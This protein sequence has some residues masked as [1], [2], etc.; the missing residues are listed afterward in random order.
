[1]KDKIVFSTTFSLLSGDGGTYRS[2]VFRR[3]MYT[4]FYFQVSSEMSLT[5]P[6]TLIVVASI[7][8]SGLKE[9]SG[10]S[11]PRRALESCASGC[12]FIL[13]ENMIKE[14]LECDDHS[15]NQLLEMEIAEKSHKD[16]KVAKLM[17]ALRLVLG[18]KWQTEPRKLFAS[19]K[20]NPSIYEHP[21]LLNEVDHAE[22]CY[23]ELKDGLEE[24]YS[25]CSA[26]C[27]MS[28]GDNKNREY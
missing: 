23:N 25:S 6:I 10:Q 13:A 22:T 3:P 1:M 11:W 15:Q 18:R 5:M 8:C 14:Y 21:E 24:L 7:F 17:K 28:S 27:R 2:Y 4:A 20:F 26:Y 16:V 19:L 9:A 12:F